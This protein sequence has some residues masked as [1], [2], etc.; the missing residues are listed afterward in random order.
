MEF[1]SESDGDG[2][3]FALWE[4]PFF[5]ST[6]LHSTSDLK[7]IWITHHRRATS[8]LVAA[9]RLVFAFSRKNGSSFSYII[10][11]HPLLCIV[12]CL[13]VIQSVNE[14]ARERERGFNWEGRKEI[15]EHGRM[16]G[17]IGKRFSDHS[18]MARLIVSVHG[19]GIGQLWYF[20][21]AHS[22]IAGNQAK[23]AARPPQPVAT[24]SILISFYFSLYLT[25]LLWSTLL[26]IS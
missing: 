17:W 10:N 3:E 21:A 19:A 20:K 11:I 26:K 14:W 7:L 8:E 15:S 16:H 12:S 22:G 9:S 24:S 18:I 5:N 25:T 4:I 13:G 2:K 6:P 1:E 23:V